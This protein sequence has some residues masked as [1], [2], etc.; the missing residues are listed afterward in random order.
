MRLDARQVK[1]DDLDGWDLLPRDLPRQVRY[2]GKREVG[3][4]RTR[5]CVVG[6]TAPSGSASSVASRRAAASTAGRSVSSSS[7]VHAKPATRAARRRVSTS[8]TSFIARSLTRYAGD[9]KAALLIGRR[10]AWLIAFI[11]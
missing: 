5:Y 2:R 3:G 9:R 8:N 11:V 1:A 10:T 7:A 6:S 4:H